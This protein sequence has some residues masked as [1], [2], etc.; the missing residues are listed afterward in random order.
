MTAASAFPRHRAPVTHLAELVPII[1]D[2]YGLAARMNAEEVHAA[3]KTIVAYSDT[4]SR[5]LAAFASPLGRVIAGRGCD[6]NTA[7]TSIVG[8]LPASRH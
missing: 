6:L 2:R 7:L 8:M 3:L 1:S 4:R 5:W